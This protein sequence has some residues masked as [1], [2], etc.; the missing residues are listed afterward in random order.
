M[1]RGRYFTAVVAAAAFMLFSVGAALAADSQTI[2]N[3]AADGQLSQSYSSADLHAAAHDATVEGYGGVTEQT[4][5]P[6][7][8]HAAAANNTPMRC[9]GFDRNGNRIMVPATGSQTAP[10]QACVKGT[11]FTQATPAAA[12]AATLPFTGLQLGGLVALGFGLVA[13]GLLL[14]RAARG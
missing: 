13:G 9:V 3:D 5:R 4:T 6:V 2:Y 8:Q 11:Q 7:V 1:R 14:R 10:S 12:P